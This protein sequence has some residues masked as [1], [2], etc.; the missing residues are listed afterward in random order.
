[1]KYN[2]T[3]DEGE[4]V[5]VTVFFEGHRPLVATKHH[6]N[7]DQIVTELA[8]GKPRPDV[9]QSLFDITTTVESKFDALKRRF[10][11]KPKKTSTQVRVERLSKKVS[12]RGGIIYYEDEP[13]HDE[14]AGVIAHY[15]ASGNEDFLPM[16]LFM[17]KLFANPN[18]HSQDNLFMW[19]KSRDFAI[20]EDGNFLAYKYV[21][22]NHKS[23]AK[24]YGVINGRVVENG[25]LDNQIGNVVEM[26]REM[27]THDPTVECSV[28]LHVGT[29]SYIEWYRR[30]QSNGGRVIAC[31]VDPR[32]VVSVPRDHGKTKL[33]VCKYE[34]TEEVKAKG[35]FTVYK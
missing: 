6:P 27:V 31:L 13:V 29:W 18:Q 35:A 20:T 17:E 21:D 15:Y 10:L 26:P 19:L 14:L 4:P 12:V 11:G 23:Y 3:S 22:R 16:V 9:V 28:G 7:F 30:M 32:D 5:S 33:R 1:M 34:V 25:H 24:G 2:V 8:T